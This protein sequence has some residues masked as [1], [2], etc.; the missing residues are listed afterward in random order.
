VKTFKKAS[1][2]IINIFIDVSFRRSL[3]SVDL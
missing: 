1:R 3:K 2:N